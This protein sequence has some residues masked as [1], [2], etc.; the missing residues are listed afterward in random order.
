MDK[1]DNRKYFID[2][3]IEQQ[4]QNINRLSNLETLIE[5]V[6][7]GTI[8]DESKALNKCINGNKLFFSKNITS[9]DSLTRFDKLLVCDDVFYEN[10]PE[11][12]NV[13]NIKL[14]SARFDN[15]V[16]GKNLFKSTKATTINLPNATFNNLLYGDTL[17]NTSSTVISL[18]NAT[19]D[20][21]I[22][23]N[24]LFNHA[25][26]PITQL[27]LPKATFAKLTNAYTLFTDYRDLETLD[28]PS[29]TFDEVQRISFNTSDYKTINVPK[30]KFDKIS[31]GRNM[32]ESCNMLRTINIPLATFDNLTN[33]TNMF[34]GSNNLTTI[35]I[36]EQGFNKIKSSLP[37]S[38]QWTW[39]NGV[40]TKAI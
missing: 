35:Y 11:T 20:N 29:A 19:F 14:S 17:F 23:Q 39:K 1:Y 6:I 9:L 33:T 38:D 31:D 10:G 22:Y 21:L 30:A 37:S 32:F 34:F 15:L 8:I 24:N 36:T 2:R 4:K 5:K 12:S 16:I 3:L 27:D 28:L 13:T 26:Q 7:L 25:L 18:P 40:A